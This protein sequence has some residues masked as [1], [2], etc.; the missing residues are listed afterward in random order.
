MKVAQVPVVYQVPAL[1]IHPAEVLP[2]LTFRYPFPE[3]TPVPVGM[4]VE[5]LVVAEVVVGV[6]LPPLGR[7]LIPLAAQVDLVPSITV[8]ISMC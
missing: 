8:V 3:N 4:D 1:M 6:P 7:Y 5:V 2:L